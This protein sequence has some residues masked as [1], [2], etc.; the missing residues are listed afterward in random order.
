MRTDLLPMPEM[1]FDDIIRF[2][3]KI[4]VKSKEECWN[5]KGSLNSQNGYGRFGIQNSYYI[6]SRIAY[7]IYYNIDPEF[8]LVCH[9]C[10]N[11]LCC[12]PNHLYLGTQSENIQQSFNELRS[13]HRGSFNSCAKLNEI[14]A[15]QIR[16]L[17]ENTSLT[18]REIGEKF[19]IAIST[20]GH[21]KYSQNWTHV[22]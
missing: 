3:G 16:N 20:V 15:K 19:G 2:W 9:S 12:N 13:I 7:W 11:T 1:L 17:L 22:K 21:I 4:D 10:N 6:T 14:K 8:K 18:L 5:W